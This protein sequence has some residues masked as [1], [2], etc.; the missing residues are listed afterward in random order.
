MNDESWHLVWNCLR[1]GIVFDA[2][3]FLNTTSAAALDAYLLEILI[4][5]AL[6]DVVVIL[7]VISIFSFM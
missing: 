6:I 1:F 4:K 5:Y 2:I 3:M 7:P